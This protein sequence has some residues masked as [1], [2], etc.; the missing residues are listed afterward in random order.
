MECNEACRQA[1]HGSAAVMRSRVSLSCQSSQ[2]VKLK[3]AQT[4]KRV[5]GFVRSCSAVLILVLNLR[6]RMSSLH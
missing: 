5:C 1:M 4:K 6:S 2:E 3:P